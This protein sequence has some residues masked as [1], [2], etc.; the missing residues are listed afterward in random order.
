MIEKRKGVKSHIKKAEKLI[1]KPG[2]VK[3]DH[4]QKPLNPEEKAEASGESSDLKIVRHEAALQEI[5]RLIKL[6]QYRL[7]DETAK[8]LGISRK[9]VGAI[10]QKL[11]DEMTEE[12]RREAE[13]RRQAHKGGPNPDKGGPNQLEING[14]LY[15]AKSNLARRA[16]F[17]LFAEYAETYVLFIRSLNDEMAWVRENSARSLGDIIE[18]HQMPQEA[19][20]KIRYSLKETL[21][22]SNM[23]VRIAAGE[24]LDKIEAQMKN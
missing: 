23:N 7:A 13:E 1:V 10:Y 6:S 4:L 20:E 18:K 15:E 24:A 22:D 3:L 17:E 9:E 16:I 8:K 21:K 2:C 11:S 12:M 19:I 5:R 14:Q